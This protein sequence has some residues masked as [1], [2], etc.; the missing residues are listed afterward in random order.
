MHFLLPQILTYEHGVCLYEGGMCVSMVQS[1]GRDQ[2]TTCSQL[3]AVPDRWNP[4]FFWPPQVFYAD[5][6]S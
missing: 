6:L 3:S 5:T 1:A 2:K 4:M